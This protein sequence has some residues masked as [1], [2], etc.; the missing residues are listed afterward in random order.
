MFNISKR[1]CGL[2]FLFRSL[3][4]PEGF[5]REAGG[6]GG[7]GMGAVIYP[8]EFCFLSFKQGDMRK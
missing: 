1:V 4:L 8:N 6:G 5:F 7:G 2:D 3:T